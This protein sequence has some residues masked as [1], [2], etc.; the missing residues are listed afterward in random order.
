MKKNLFFA[1]TIISLFSNQAI[2]SVGGKAELSEDLSSVVSIGYFAYNLAS[3]G[4]PID[5]D[6]VCTGTV[7]APQKVLTTAGCALS[8]KSQKEIDPD[9]TFVV[10]NGRNNLNPR[11]IFSK[12]NL[13]TTQAYENLGAETRKITGFAVH[14]R[15]KGNKLNVWG[16]QNGPDLGI[17]T[18]EKPFSW[19]TPMKLASKKTLADLGDYTA[20]TFSGFGLMPSNRLAKNLQSIE[21]K[22][23]PRSRCL[24]IG[25]SIE[26]VVKDKTG[27]PKRNNFN[28]PS[29][30]QLCT[31]SDDE[32]FP[33]TAQGDWGGPLT[34]KNKDG[35]RELIGVSSW[36]FYEENISP[37]FGGYTCGTRDRLGARSLNGFEKPSEF[38]QFIED[39]TRLEL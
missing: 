29:P 34:I 14:P 20:L 28:G 36:S 15:Y 32:A 33:C 39:H 27:Q 31:L 3:V 26:K 19:A 21:L 1:A 30:T 7:I 6:Q 24:S 35:D 23:L 17:I 11:S 2:S 38:M 22:T 25:K 5:Y 12:N 16:A 18:I 13:D 8:L 37:F 4:T 10:L 9:I